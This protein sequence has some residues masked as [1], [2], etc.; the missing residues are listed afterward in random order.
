MGITG[1]SL[2]VDHTFVATIT[3]GYPPHNFFDLSRLLEIRRAF[4]AVDNDPQA[5]VILLAS[6]GK[7]FCAGA[8]FA[9]SGG[10]LGATTGASGS[11]SPS[12]GSGPP[13]LADADLAGLHIYDLA[14]QLFACQTPVIAAVQG[15]AVGGGLGLACMADLRVGGPSTRLSANF[16]KLG[17]HQGFGLSVTLPAIAGQQVAMDL[18]YTGRRLRGDEAYRVGLLDRYVENDAEIHKEA[19]ALASEIAQSAPLA[20]NSIRRTLRG[21]LA[22]QVRE[23]CDH[24]RA[25]QERLVQTNDWSE[26]VAAM[27]ER[28]T[29]RFQGN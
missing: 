27:T 3:L 14:V 16:A 25:E 8:D 1:V 28:R 13:L 15:A 4:V 9:S 2:T 19:Y 20:I 11:T 23:A 17:F 7:N 5:R 6:E 24:E 12:P 18:L 22:Q 26:G 21:G 10:S 29:P